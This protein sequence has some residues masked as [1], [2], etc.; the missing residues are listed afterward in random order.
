MLMVTGFRAVAGGAPRGEC[1]L[2]RTWRAGSTKHD[3]DDDEV[4]GRAAILKA[5]LMVCMFKEA[6][7]SGLGWCLEPNFPSRDFWTGPG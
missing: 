3:G 5:D 4:S 6:R 7:D 2:Q 1:E